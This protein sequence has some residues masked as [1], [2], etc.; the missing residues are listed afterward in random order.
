MIVEERWRIFRTRVQIPPGPLDCEV[1]NPHPNK[2]YEGLELAVYR[3][4]F[5]LILNLDFLDEYYEEQDDTK[6]TITF[7][8]IRACVK[9]RFDVDVSNSS[10]SQVKKKCC[11]DSF[12]EQ[13]ELLSVDGIKSDKEKMILEAF[14]ELGIVV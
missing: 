7:A 3:N 9:Q 6:Q 12:D 5:A 11:I 10:I 8:D 4:C 13:Y 2:F 1:T 14:M